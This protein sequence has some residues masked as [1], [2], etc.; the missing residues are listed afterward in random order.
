MLAKL[1]LDMTGRIVLPKRLRDELQLAPGD[2]LEMETSGE[3]I[4]LRPVRGNASLRKKRGIWVY[5]AGEPLSDAV[6]QETLRR[7]R[8]ERD[9]ENLKKGS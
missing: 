5:S 9:E 2:A 7:A 3:K 6:V 1:R 4:T 8:R